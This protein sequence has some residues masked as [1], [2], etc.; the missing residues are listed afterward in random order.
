[1]VVKYGVSRAL[2]PNFNPTW[3]SDAPLDCVFNANGSTFN[4]LL[5]EHLSVHSVSKLIAP[6]I[7]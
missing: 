4:V 2:S 7:P 5:D 1:M 6:L 3:A